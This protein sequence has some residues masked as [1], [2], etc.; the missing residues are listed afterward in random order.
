M[1]RT[2]KLIRTMGDW[3]GTVLAGLVIL[4]LLGLMAWIAGMVWIMA[5]DVLGAVSRAL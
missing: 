1:P 3:G 5:F 4:T 2:D